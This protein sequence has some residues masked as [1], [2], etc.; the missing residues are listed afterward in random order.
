M[1]VVEENW[2]T[3]RPTMRERTK[4]VLNNYRFSDVKFVAHGSDGESDSKQAI[5]A[6]KFVLS[7]GSPVSV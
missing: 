2:Q 6:H 5:P 7:I 1:S 4:F 3:T